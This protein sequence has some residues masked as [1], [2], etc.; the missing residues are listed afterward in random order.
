MIA[1]LTAR[2]G[3]TAD[4]A[5]ERI[6]LLTNRPRGLAHVD[7]TATEATIDQAITLG[8]HYLS[9]HQ[10]R[11]GA[12]VDF[13]LHPGASTEWIT[14]HVA[15]V[16]EPVPQARQLTRR[17]AD[18]LASV[19]R[20]EGGWGYCRRVAND[21]DSTAQ[22]LMVLTHHQIRPP[23]FVI[24]WLLAAQAPSG[25][26]PTYPAPLRSEPANGWQRE[27]ADVTL[28][29][30]EAI[31]RLDIKPATQNRALRWL[32]T[33]TARPLIQSYWWSSPA[34]AGWAQA[35]TGF[36]ADE[37][38]AEACRLIRGHDGVPALPMLIMAASKSGH[39]TDVLKKQALTTL[40]AEQWTDGSWPC[41]PCLRVTDATRNDAGNLDGPTFAGARRV[42][43]TA[44]AVAA[45]AACRGPRH[46]L[47]AV[48]STGANSRA[49]N[50]G[51]IDHA[52]AASTGQVIVF[53]ETHQ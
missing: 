12:W 13:L 4:A 53:R 8:I 38:G 22:A 51:E 11:N 26:F 31:R 40:I 32:E 33:T 39:L 41:Q 1:G 49:A 10:R 3:V 2:L 18:Y 9:R 24:D 35:R 28:M 30:V 34:Y 27:H 44:H 46:S 16:L 15:F 19:G 25:G 50:T 14:A 43:S 45:L 21:C 5:S 29:V 42:F 20:S 7:P 23:R 36:R 52:P 17:A 48:R 37:A 47:Q 6:F